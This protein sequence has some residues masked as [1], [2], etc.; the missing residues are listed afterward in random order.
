MLLISGLIV[1]V[2]RIP[3][4]HKVVKRKGLHRIGR[5]ALSDKSWIVGIFLGTPWPC[6]P[7]TNQYFY[8]GEMNA[9]VD[10]VTLDSPL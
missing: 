4:V 1:C 3:V 6:D 2:N 9:Q 8:H 7:R 10:P 5:T